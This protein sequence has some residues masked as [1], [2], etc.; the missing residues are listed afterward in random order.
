[1]IKFTFTT[2]ALAAELNRNL[3]KGKQE[4]HRPF[5]Y[6]DFVKDNN[7]PRVDFIKMDIEGAEPF[8]LNGAVETI[9]RFKP[10]LAI[11]IYH[12]M[13]DFVN[14]PEWITGLNLG[15]KL[16]LGHYTIHSEETI[17]FAKV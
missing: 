6:D 12:S 8:A 7:I 17:L 3:L 14:I 2:K 16:Y 4:L 11:A 13:D 10:K 15:Y 9:K 5:Q 1:M